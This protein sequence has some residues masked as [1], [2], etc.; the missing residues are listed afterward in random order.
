[1]AIGIDNSQEIDAVMRQMRRLGEEKT[2]RLHDFQ[3][4]D[5]FV[6]LS[7]S[8]SNFSASIPGDEP[9]LDLD[10]LKQLESQPWPDNLL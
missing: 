8:V 5:F 10:A 3:F 2:F 9:N 4:R 1:M 7:Q 6:W